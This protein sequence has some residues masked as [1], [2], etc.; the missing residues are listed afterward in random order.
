MTYRQIKVCNLVGIQKG[1]VNKSGFNQNLTRLNN[2]ILLEIYYNSFLFY[3]EKLKSILFLIMQ[4]K[5]ILTLK[6][7]LRLKRNIMNVSDDWHLQ[8]LQL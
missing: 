5:Q 6:L 2:S 4:N 1:V 8:F 7:F 3:R